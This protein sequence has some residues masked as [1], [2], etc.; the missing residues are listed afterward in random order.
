MTFHFTEKGVFK[1]NVEL[2]N[3]ISTIKYDLL[4]VTNFGVRKPLEGEVINIVRKKLQFFAIEQ[5]CGP[6]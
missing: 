4:Q 1:P 3:E 5:F 6:Y 2:G